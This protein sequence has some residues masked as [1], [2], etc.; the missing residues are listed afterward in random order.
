VL[1]FWFF[2]FAGGFTHS[3]LR[4]PY[5]L[6]ARGPGPAGGHLRLLSGAIPHTHFE[7]SAT[8]GSP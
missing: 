6:G 4:A 3:P 5:F 7:S 1:F 8:K 2:V